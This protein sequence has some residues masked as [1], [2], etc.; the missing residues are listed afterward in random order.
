MHLRLYSFFT[1]YPWYVWPDGD[2]ADWGRLGGGFMDDV[3]S[4]SDLV[5]LEGKIRMETKADAIELC[6]QL[7]AGE[8]MTFSRCG[9]K[10]IRSDPTWT[11]VLLALGRFTV[12]WEVQGRIGPKRR[13]E[14]GFEAPYVGRV[15]WFLYDRYDFKWWVLAASL[16]EL[17]G[18]GHDYHVFSRWDT[19]IDGVVRCG[20]SLQPQSS[21]D[22]R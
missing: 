10:L 4:Q 17:V 15:S 13:T 14:D 1:R 22:A 11:N 5:E 20:T 7:E 12:Y 2:S 21:S 18:I 19:R 6:S 8:R 16:W 3:R 9:D